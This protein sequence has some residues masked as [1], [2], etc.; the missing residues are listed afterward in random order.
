MWSKYLLA[1]AGERGSTVANSYSRSGKQDKT[2]HVASLW[3]K[4]TK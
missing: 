3:A 2:F 1:N 4:L